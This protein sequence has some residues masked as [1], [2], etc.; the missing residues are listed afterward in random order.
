MFQPSYI[1]LNFQDTSDFELKAS[2]ES[3][4]DN[5]RGSSSKPLRDDAR[6]YSGSKEAI[7][8]KYAALREQGQTSHVKPMEDVGSTKVSLLDSANPRSG[9][10]VAAPS[11]LA[12]RWASMKAGFQNFKTNIEAKRLIP[13][14]QVGEFI[15][16]RQAQDTNVS[17]ASS[18][19][20][21]DDIFNKL[22]RPASESEN[23]SDD[24]GDERIPRR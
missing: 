10:T 19:E 6:R 11:G 13:L 2:L 14:R 21:L 5:F 12:G 17:R 1:H 8:S 23:Y 16:L 7:S 22:K 9:S 20:S 15:P 3:S 24:D 4:K 18:S